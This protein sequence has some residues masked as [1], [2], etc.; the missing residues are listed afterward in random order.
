MPSDEPLPVY[1]HHEVFVVGGQPTVTYNARP[2][3]GVEQRVRDYLEERNR[4]L[5]I[6]GPSKSG[7]TVLVRE[8]VGQAIRLSGGDLK[9]I[10]EFW[11][12]IVDTMG[13]FTE[14][15]GERTMVESAASTDK[16]SVAFKPGGVGVEAGSDR[17]GESATQQTRGKARSKGERNVA[18]RALRKLKHSIVID[19]FHHI[20]PEVQCEIVR[21]VKDLVF[22]GVPVIFVAVPHRAADV[23]RAEPEM[24]RRVEHLEITPWS[25]T[26][27][28]EIASR[29]F[30]ALNI[31]CPD[32]L[33]EALA[34]ESY[35]SPHLMQDFCLQICKANKVEE[36]LNERISLRW[37]G[38]LKTFFSR[39][40]SREGEGEVYRR[41]AQGPRQ[42]SDRKRRKLRNGQLTDLYGVVLSAIAR[43]GPEI[44]IDWT[45]IRTALREVME[46]DPPRKA[47]YTK[48]LEHMSK[49]A[50]ELVYDKKHRRYFGDPALEYDS[51]LDKVHISD[52]FFAFQLRW[53]VRQWE[54]G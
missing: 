53:S 23:V 13:E 39:I 18:K 51:E 33:S 48:A 11:S 15:A 52:P 44:E 7:K 22:E 16:V 30:D 54:S 29:G 9:S 20:H 45:E 50:R 5:C 31:D 21:G 17:T 14:E 46:D 10:E 2:R 27:L 12:E 47:E 1:R 4:I 19:D 41:L 28:E 38:Q 8:V 32:A 40:A 37:K 43:T 6:T 36:T 49:I 34:R 3:I 24:T 25:Q 35:G 26:E 42:R